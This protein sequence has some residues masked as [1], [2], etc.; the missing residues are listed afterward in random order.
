MRISNFMLWQ[1]AY[2]EL[3]ISDV[4]WP[5][6]SRAHLDEAFAAYRKRQRRYG[7]TGAQTEKKAGRA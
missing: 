7:L 5:A 6:F 2:T 3:Y 4:P 1:I